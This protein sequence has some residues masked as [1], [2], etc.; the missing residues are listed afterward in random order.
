MNLKDKNLSLVQ[1]MFYSF[2]SP[3]AHHLPGEVSAVNSTLAQQFGLMSF[4]DFQ[5]QK[6]ILI[7]E[8]K[9]AKNV[10]FDDNEAKLTRLNKG[11]KIL[12]E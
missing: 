5:G 1:L 6:K 10:V 7:K 4:A 8:E 12:P 11:Q 2:T 3:V 9:K